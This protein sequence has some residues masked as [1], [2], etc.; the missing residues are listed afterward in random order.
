M[1]FA[2]KWFVENEINL[3]L[4]FGVSAFFTHMSRGIDITNVDVA[5]LDQPKQSIN[6]FAN[7]ELN[8]KNT[9]S[10]V[11]LDVWLLPFVNFYGMLG[12]VS[13]NAS[14]D[15]TITIDRII[16]PG[17]PVIIPINSQSKLNGSYV[18]LGT[19]MVA[20]YG[21]WFILGDANYGY[22]K[23]DEFESEIDF[24]MFSAR[25]GFQSSLGKNSM[26]AWLGGMY[27]SSNRTL[28]L[29]VQDENLGL[30]QVDVYQKTNNPLTLQLGTSIGIGKHFEILTEL[31][32]NFDD[33]SIGVFSGSYRF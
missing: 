14:L 11:K 4:P 28:H 29:N 2:K 5:L 3:P 1:P 10:A 8:N 7:F 16:L 6:D 13:T 17:P 22:S 25:S 9:V 21:S 32:T 30:V 33:A 24:W 20:G 26:R 12:Y 19:T 31:G 15:A 18:G 27:L 23:L